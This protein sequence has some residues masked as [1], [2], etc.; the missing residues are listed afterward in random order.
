M[1]WYLKKDFFDTVDDL[2]AVLI[3]Y[4][5]AP[6]GMTAD[7]S[8][9][10]SRLMPPGEL[11]KTSIGQVASYG[12]PPPAI[13]QLAHPRLRRQVLRLPDQIWDDRL[14]A[15]TG[16][17]SL[18]YCYE[19]VRSGER[20]FSSVYTDEMCT[21]DVVFVDP[22]GV[23][24]GVSAYWSV[25]D[26]E[27][28]QLSPMEDPAFIAIF[29]EDHPLRQ[30]NFSGLAGSADRE[31][32]AIAKKACIDVLPLPRR[33]TARV[34]APAGAPVRLRFLVG[35]WGLPEH[36][37]WEDYWLDETFVMTRGAEPLVV[38]PLGL[39]PVAAPLT[40]VRPE[41]L[42]GNSYAPLLPGYL[43]SYQ[44]SAP[45]ESGPVLA[46]PVPAGNNAPRI[47]STDGSNGSRNGHSKGHIGSLVT[48]SPVREALSAGL[49]KL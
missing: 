35:N 26:W 45:A 16:E 30:Q 34:S 29:G 38:A 25:Y 11:L 23:I 14:G 49:A 33:F 43:P 2:E 40:R 48:S 17:Y 39:Q 41:L 12:P 21:R 19:I 22:L 47:G 3:H 13:P 42:A 18:H 27:A 15:S 6:R 44:P 5:C 20:F 36:Q 31:A 1:K 32:F 7:W 24:G 37:R 9:A 10:E 46:G 8:L 28:P 4:T